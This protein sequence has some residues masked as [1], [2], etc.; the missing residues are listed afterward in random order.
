MNTE[1]N[2]L[3]KI[4]WIIIAAVSGICII[5]IITTWTGKKKLTGEWEKNLA[6]LQK[7]FKIQKL[8]PTTKSIFIMQNEYKWLVKKQKAIWKLLNSKKI[9]MSNA[10][11]L[12]F[13][14][15]LFNTQTKLRQL[16][17][18]QGC[19]IPKNIGFGE[20]SGGRIPSA[21]EV[22][23]LG[24]RLTIIEEIINL[25]LKYKLKEIVSINYLQEIYYSRQR[26]YKQFLF[27]IEVQ[28]VYE[29]LLEFLRALPEA[30]FFI[31][32]KSIELDKVDENT[33]KAKIVL[34]VTE[35][36][37]FKVKM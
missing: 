4:W 9:S 6:E 12:A 32:V 37:Q 17:D 2:R 14:E 24:K 5:M 33:V 30:S 10:A 29:N 35:F 16:A 18:I 36:E 3:F 27:K 19:S 8:P 1:K 23:L 15:R 31:A 11:P 34:G 7:D 13:K 26:L 20:Y 28:C 21:G 25:A 22:P